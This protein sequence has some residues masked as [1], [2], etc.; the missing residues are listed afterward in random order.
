VP[1]R[2]PPPGPSF[3][4]EQDVRIGDRRLH[5]GMSRPTSGPDEWWLTVLWV[6]DDEGVA[7]FADVAPPSGPPADPPLARLGPAIAG[8]LSGLIREESGRLAVRLTPVV[9][10]EDPTRPWRCPLAVRAAFKWEA[11]RQ[12]ALPSTQLAELVLTGFRGSVEGLHR[13]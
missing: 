12:A 11:V 5:A 3:I 2:L 7:S 4:R 9:A 13:H 8:A 1:D 10:P 6:A